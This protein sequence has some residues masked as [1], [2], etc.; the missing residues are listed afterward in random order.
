MPRSSEVRVNQTAPNEPAAGAVPLR[1]ALAVCALLVGT[2]AAFGDD[3]ATRV[4]ELLDAG[5]AAEARNAA[6]A[7]VERAPDETICWRWLA[8]ACERL[9]RW[10]EA[11]E[12]WV[13]YAAITRSRINRAAAAEHLAW[14]RA[15]RKGETPAAAGGASIDPVALGSVD[16]SFTTARSA[17]FVVKSRNAQLTRLVADRAEEYLTSLCRTFLGDR[18]WAHEIPITIY[19][20]HA[21]YVGA[22]NPA[23]SGGGTAFRFEEKGALDWKIKR[24]IDLFQL[25]AEGKL[26]PELLPNTLPHELTH[27]VLS[28]HFGEHAVPLWLT[29][30]L[31]Q[32]MESVDP[33]YYDKVVVAD[34]NSGKRFY[35]PIPALVGLPKY[36]EGS[37]PKFLFY[38][39]SASFTRFLLANLPRERFFEFVDDVKRGFTAIAGLGQ[40]FAVPPEQVAERLEK[41]WLD[42][43]VQKYGTSIGSLEE[44]EK[45]R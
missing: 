32:L 25:G 24:S 14:C 30:G 41:K 7:R 1:L 27:L 16:A 6:R 15:R 9:E 34:L 3:G 38:R 36:P 28:E 42:G 29:E 4:K 39:E 19:R 18:A 35:V 2:A 37:G 43:L 45:S 12:T 21:E 11:E 31:A 33:D 20:D 5:Q 8:L 26:D 40:V 13:A 44:A 17:H 23:W 22:G 10:D